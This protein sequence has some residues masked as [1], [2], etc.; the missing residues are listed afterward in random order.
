MGNHPVW[1]YLEHAVTHIPTWM[2]G[3]AGF[4]TLIL[5]HLE[6]GLTRTATS[7]TAIALIAT[8]CYRVWK[9]AGKLIRRTDAIDEVVEVQVPRLIVDVAGLH[10]GLDQLRSAHEK[11]AAGLH[12]GQAEI[13]QALAEIQDR[14]KQR[15]AEDPP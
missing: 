8:A 12:H 2:V 9:L 6:S 7:V 11:D 4:A 5:S 13:Q 3:M 1:H 15:R 14:A 10:Q